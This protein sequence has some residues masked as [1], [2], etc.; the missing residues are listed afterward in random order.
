MTDGRLAGIVRDIGDIVLSGQLGLAKALALSESATQQKLDLAVETAEFIISPVLE[1]VVDL[2][3][4]AQ[5]E[6]L[7]GHRNM[8]WGRTV[9]HPRLGA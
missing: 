1:G 4:D 2:F 7:S 6:T 3:V 5:Q 8:G 9:S